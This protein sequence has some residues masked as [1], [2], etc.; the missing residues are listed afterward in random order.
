MFLAMFLKGELELKCERATREGNMAVEEV[1]ELMSMTC[2]SRF[3]AFVELHDVEMI[4]LQENVVGRLENGL[5]L[6][7]KR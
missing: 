1:G 7:V 5:I 3:V 6:M 2:G 4:S